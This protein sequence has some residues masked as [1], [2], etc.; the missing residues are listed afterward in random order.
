MSAVLKKRKRVQHPGGGKGGA[1]QSMKDE[2]DINRIM[3]RYMKTGQVD[4]LNRY[5][6]QYGFVPSES[7]H[8]SMEIV[9][10]AEE[11]FMALDS[12]IRA[13]FENDPGAFLEFVQDP[14]NLDEMRE[15]GLAKPAEAPPI[16]VE[17]S[18]G[19]SS[20]PSSSPAP[21]G[22]GPGPSTS[23]PPKGGKGGPAQ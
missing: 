16:P 2:C 10:K 1:K 5:G 7:F 21:S 23:T 11:M 8:E 22:D 15:L 4:H 14:K 3:A 12:S 19:P 6:G 20:S 18:S 13:K 9:R 17:R